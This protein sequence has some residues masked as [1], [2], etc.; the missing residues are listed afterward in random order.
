MTR[1][2]LP[3][4]VQDKAQKQQ[5]ENKYHRLCLSILTGVFVFVLLHQ[6]DNFELFVRFIPIL[7]MKMMM[8]MV[9]VTAHVK[10]PQHTSSIFAE[11]QR[12]HRDHYTRDEADHYQP[13]VGATRP[14]QHMKQPHLGLAMDQPIVKGESICK[15]RQQIKS[16]SFK[17]AFNCNLFS[18]D[19]CVPHRIQR[20]LR[21]AERNILQISSIS[22]SSSE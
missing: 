8:A 22:D 14:A 2:S 5:R 11:A 21:S 13:Q 12:G 10:Q 19:F 6:V 9:V 7:A 4:P 18:V 16:M 20:Y 17:P 15:R 3:R 1:C